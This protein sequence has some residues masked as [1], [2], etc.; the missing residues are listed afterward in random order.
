MLSSSGE[1]IA[2]PTFSI[3]NPVRRRHRFGVPPS[4]ELSARSKSLLR[5]GTESS[6]SSPSSGESAA[7]FSGSF[8]ER[9]SALADPWGYRRAFNR[10]RPLSAV[11]AH[12]DLARHSRQ[13]RPAGPRATADRQ[14]A[15]PGGT[16]SE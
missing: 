15:D 10:E 16:R 2:N 3:R 9:P 11:A 7:N 12:P 6:N 1:S 13:V 14:T 8:S 5:R 4:R